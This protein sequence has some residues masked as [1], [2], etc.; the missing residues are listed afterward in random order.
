MSAT[1]NVTVHYTVWSDCRFDVLAAQLGC[2]VDSAIGRMVRLWSECTDRAT[3]TPPRS[4]V[5]GSLK[6]A[7]ACEALLASDLAELTDS[8]LRIRG[9]EK[10]ILWLKNKRE[11]AAVGGKASVKSRKNSKKPASRVLNVSS[12]DAQAL[13]KQESS[14]SLTGA[15]ANVEHPSSTCS[16]LAQ[17]SGTQVFR[18]SGIQESRNPATQ[19]PT[20]GSAPNGAALEK[21][22]AVDCR[23]FWYSIF[24][25]HKAGAKATWGD[26]QGAQLKRL[27]GSHDAR[28]IKR[29]MVNAFDAPPWPFDPPADFMGFVAQFDKFA[30]KHKSRPR[31]GGGLEALLSDIAAAEGRG[32]Q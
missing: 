32:A 12:T 6:S 19:E 9:T 23:E 17:P 13:A 28:E 4:V 27:L 11:A 3:T 30:V 25:A 22:A 1:A 8:G 21:S 29:R 7:T 5:I 24:A 31:E 16:T 2:D 15:Q 10:R 14:T 18:D 20:E 26:K